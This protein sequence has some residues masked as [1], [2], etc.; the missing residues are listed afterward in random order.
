MELEFRKFEKIARLKRDMIITE[1]IDG[2]NGQIVIQQT[3]AIDS[4]YL[5]IT[6][7]YGMEVGE[8]T[9]LAGSRKR[10]ITPEVD[11]YGF[12]RWVSENREGLLWLGE[13][14]HY[15]EW[16]G[17]GIQRRY[18]MDKKVFS[19]FNVHRWDTDNIPGD[20]LRVVPV[21]YRG[22]FN[23]D[24]IDK[25]LALLKQFGSMAAPGFM[26][27]EGVVV[28]MVQARTLF[29]VTIKDD[30]IPKSLIKEK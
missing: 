26:K 30:G 11:N 6:E 17:S 7:Q 22:P 14:R 23:T 25:Q 24:V 1:K 27:P 18:D 3:S 13:G 28:Y 4:N 29:K 21:L 2:T 12:A 9:M 19:L 8:Y 10:Y 20:I 5:P 15:G 16:W